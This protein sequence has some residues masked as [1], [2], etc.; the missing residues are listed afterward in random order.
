[1]ARQPKPR[2]P[3]RTRVARPKIL[4]LE[5]APPRLLDERLFAVREH[6]LGNGLTVR[7]LED[8]SVPAVSLYTFFRV[9][10]RN[11]R[12][13]RTGIAHLFEH[14]MFNGAARYG[15]KE[16]DRV[17]E[18]HGGHSNA[19]TSHDVTAY[20]ED[21]AAESLELVLDLE[22]DRMRSLAITPETLASEREVV[23]EERRYAI[24][25]SP[26]GLLDETLQAL[27]FQAHPYG[28]PVIGW[29]DDIDAITR[30]DCLEFFRTY[31]APNN[32][33][34]WA[35]GDFDSDR[36]LDLIE[37]AYGDI[38]S[39]P[40]VTPPATTEPPQR[41][42]RRAEVLFPAHAQALAI[43]YR[44]PA[45]SSPDA[46]ALDVLQYALSAGHG[47]RL[48][49][50]LVYEKLLAATLFT[51]FTWHLDPGLFSVFMELN[52]G[53]RAEKAQAALD[54]ELEK[55]VNAGLTESELRRAKGLLRSHLLHEIASNNGR[56]HALG[57]N[58]LLLGDWRKGLE[59]ARR[60]EEVGDEDVRRVAAAV[61][62]R[63]LRSTAV[64][65]PDGTG[66][67]GSDD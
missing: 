16:F 51:D 35:V 37:R 59:L 62:R 11:E 15:P 5:L 28:W 25:N 7:L 2:K 17:L 64:L 41:G 31:Y 58:E 6:R 32:A 24:E 36:A 23:K 65:V 54:D 3:T 20:F 63:E 56:G 67:G 29:M 38:P 22:S 19:Y 30:E 50:A 43:G 44:A 42:E 33:T 8:R 12:P 21:F 60:Y 13:G 66:E 46:P 34:V 45:G 14:M 18:A 27:A 52:P 57:T 48:V 4:G 9:G 49:R 53:V 47:G 1:M 10:A 39:G 61:L 26:L 40:P 55:V